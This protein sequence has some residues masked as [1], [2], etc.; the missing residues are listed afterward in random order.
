MPRTPWHEPVVQFVGRL[1]SFGSVAML[2]VS[3]SVDSV[4]SIS[5]RGPVSLAALATRVLKSLV[6][7][8]AIIGKPPK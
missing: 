2:F 1:F 8:L 5:R 7:I 3:L 6:A 4:G